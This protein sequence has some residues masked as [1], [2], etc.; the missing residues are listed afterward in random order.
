MKEL[1]LKREYW[2]QRT[3]GNDSKS[4]MF[5]FS[6]DYMLSHTCNR[7]RNHL[8]I[9]KNLSVIEVI[10]VRQSRCFSAMLV[11]QHNSSYIYKEAE[12]LFIP[13]VIILAY[14]QLISAYGVGQPDP[15][16]RG[17]DTVILKRKITIYF[18]ILNKIIS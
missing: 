8:T 3:R 15:R 2:W 18:Y 14:Y 11:S 16:G 1:A 4:N 12:L 13:S 7:R 10:K 9:S 5:H 17:R 6:L